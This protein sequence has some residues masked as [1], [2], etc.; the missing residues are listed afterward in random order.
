M[1]RKCA[2]VPDEGVNEASTSA[3]G[4][5]VLNRSAEKRNPATPARQ[6]RGVW[7]TTTSPQSVQT[8]A[9]AQARRRRREVRTTH[10]V[11]SDSTGK[12]TSKAQE[13][14]KTKKNT[15]KTRTTTETLF[16]AHDRS[17]IDRH[18]TR[19]TT[20][21][22]SATT[23]MQVQ[24]TARKCSRHTRTRSARMQRRQHRRERKGLGRRTTPV[25]PPP[26]LGF[27]VHH[28]VPLNVHV[29]LRCSPGR[30]C[31]PTYFP[32]FHHKYY[33]SYSIEKNS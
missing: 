6:W 4:C 2:E 9:R 10:N 7:K 20:T 12:A 8:E 14:L 5:A 11:P 19:T 18:R 24:Y 16:P 29:P 25:Y 22:T 32:Y 27:P 31:S 30:A 23:H 26:A 3:N 33:K 21:T 15:E 17:G 28:F 13:V 1:R